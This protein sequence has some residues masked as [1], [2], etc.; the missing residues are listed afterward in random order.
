MLQ[1]IS[2]GVV[3][4]VIVSTIKIAQNNEQGMF[5]ILSIKVHG[6]RCNEEFVYTDILRNYN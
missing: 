1:A 2:V 3:T 6:I 4:G 5:G